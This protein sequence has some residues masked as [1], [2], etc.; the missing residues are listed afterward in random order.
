M[1]YTALWIKYSDVWGQA[2]NE[3]SVGTNHNV[4]SVQQKPPYEWRALDSPVAA[5][6]C[7][8]IGSGVPNRLPRAWRDPHGSS[9]DCG[10]QIRTSK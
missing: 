7:K 8:Q 4:C 2:K 10:A 5:A 6:P 3:D 9:K 1:L